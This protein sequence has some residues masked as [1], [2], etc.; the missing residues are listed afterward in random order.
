MSD[1]ATQSTEPAGSA[2]IDVM[3][4]DI[5][6]LRAALTKLRNEVG[7]ILGTV[8]AELQDAAGLTN[9]SVLELRYKEANEALGPA[10]EPSA[11]QPERPVAWFRWGGSA[12][13]P[14]IAWG[15]W[16]PGEPDDVV[17]YPLYSTPQGRPAHKTSV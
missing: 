7:G 16:P 10:D 6:R 4:R 2:E 8:K 11:E 17:W 1:P 3:R 14:I 12:V 15:D 5:H 9:V 13:K